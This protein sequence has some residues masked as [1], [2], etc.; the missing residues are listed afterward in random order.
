MATEA[1]NTALVFKPDDIKLTLGETEYRL[2]Y[3]LN[4][5][6]ELEKKYGSID[7][8]LQ[9]ML[10][11]GQETAPVIKVDG[12]E[13]DIKAVTVDDTPL[14]VVLAKLTDQPTA[15]LSDTAE[16]LYAGVL[17]DAA[18]YN[19]HGEIVK[20]T[21]AKQKLCSE[22]TLRNIREINMK[23]AAAILRD[24]VPAQETPEEAKN[25]DAPENATE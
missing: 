23:I 25:V 3:D 11:T 14:A 19:Q 13:T 10:G 1:K 7:N 5:F 4:A 22:I 24:L 8:I 17:H 9:L 15:T 21:V 20:Y 12:I 18:V 16:L 2:V 6:C